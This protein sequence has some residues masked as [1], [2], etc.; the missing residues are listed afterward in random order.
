MH[1]SVFLYTL[2]LMECVHVCL[3]VGAVLNNVKASVLLGSYVVSES[4][5]FFDTLR[6]YLYQ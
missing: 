6:V 5:L 2:I 4:F 3:I 1:L